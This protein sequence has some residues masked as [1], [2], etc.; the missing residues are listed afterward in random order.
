MFW[1]RIAFHEKSPQ[2]QWLAGKG[3]VARFYRD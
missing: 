3:V 1:R 2:A